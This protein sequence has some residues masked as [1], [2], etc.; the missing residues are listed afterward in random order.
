[1]LRGLLPPQAVPLPP[2]GRHFRASQFDCFAAWILQTLSN[3]LRVICK[4]NVIWRV[5]LSVQTSLM[6]PSGRGLR[7]RR[8]RRVRENRVMLSS[9][10]RRLLPPQAV[11]LP[12]GGRHFRASQF[13]CFAAWMLQTLSN[14][15]RFIGEMN[16]IK[17]WKSAR[18]SSLTL[19]F[20]LCT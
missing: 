6:A 5:N 8:W 1:M 20:A 18:F 19:H 3:K 16:P 12:P 13:D 10:S 17:I 15:L 4:A 2:G 9:K 7:R 14:K 11:P